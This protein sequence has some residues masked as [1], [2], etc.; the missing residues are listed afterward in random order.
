M[1]SDRP[2][3]AHAGRGGEAGKSAVKR[4]RVCRAVCP[5]RRVRSDCVSIL[6]LTGVYSVM[7]VGIKGFVTSLSLSDFH[8]GAGLVLTTRAAFRLDAM[9]VYQRVFLAQI[10]VHF[11]RILRSPSQNQRLS[12]QSELL[13]LF[14]C[15]SSLFS[16]IDII[17]I[18]PQTSPQSQ[19]RSRRPAGTGREITEG[20]AISICGKVAESA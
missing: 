19:F 9:A 7:L 4:T 12:T 18:L 20:Q 2:S 14:R 6:I 17:M 11:V 13:A 8:Q 3:P 1:S 16:G 5:P 10:M 15:L